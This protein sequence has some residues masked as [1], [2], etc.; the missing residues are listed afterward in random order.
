MRDGRAK[1][2]RWEDLRERVLATLARR[3]SEPGAR[4]R[5]DSA[6]REAIRLRAAGLV[7]RDLREADQQ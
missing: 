1:E 7:A 5:A 3:L 4:P 2:P 6:V